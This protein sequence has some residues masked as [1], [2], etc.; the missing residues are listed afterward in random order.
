V[1]PAQ[2]E[3]VAFDHYT[4]KNGLSNNEVNDLIQDDDGF[5]WIATRG[6]LNRFDGKDFTKYYTDGSPEQLPSNDIYR[7]ARFSGNRILVGTLKG[8]A[9]FNTRTGKIS[10]HIIPGD[11]IL[12]TYRNRIVDIIVDSSQ[13]VIVATLTGVFV[14]DSAFKLIFRYEPFT[15]TD[16]GKKRIE[17]CYSFQLLK[18]GNI[19]IPA[20]NDVFLLDM[21]SKSMQS[22]GALAA[23]DWQLFNPWRTS[24]HQLFHWKD[25]S[26]CFVFNYI[27]KKDSLNLYE[28]NFARHRVYSM[29][30]PFAQK[31]EIHW[32]SNIRFLND[33]TIGINSSFQNGIYLFHFDS[34]ANSL[35]YSGKLLS[36]I[37]C[38]RI[39][40]D[41]EKRLWISSDD[42]VFKQSFQKS[43]FHN[44]YVRGI[45]GVHN[46]DNFV[47]GF[48]KIGNKLFVSVYSTGVII[49]GHQDKLQASGSR[50][51]IT[52]IRLPWNIIQTSK[53]SLLIPTQEGAIILNA[54][55]EIQ[56][57]FWKPGLPPSLDKVAITSIFLDSRNRLWMGM[58]K[59]F[60]VFMIN[61]NNQV[62]QIFDP[63]DGP[64]PFPIRYPVA[65]TE[66]RKGNIWMSGIEGI[67]RWNQFKQQF[68]TLI[69]HI[70]GLSEDISGQWISVQADTSGNLWI[71]P[72]EFVLIKWNLTNS[73]FK[74]FRTPVNMGALRA[75]QIQGPCNG[76]LWIPTNAGLLSFEI[77]TEKF[78][79]IKEADGLP[80]DNAID[81][82]MYFDST[83]NKMYAGFDKAFTWF[84][85]KKLLH[86]EHIPITYITDV[87]AIGD[88][89]SKA[90]YDQARFTHDQNSIS[91][92]FAGVN[93]DNGQ[94]N[95][96]AYRIFENQPAG[97][98][99]IGSQNTL[100]FANL[101]PG[102]YTFQVK[103][104]GTN[105]LSNS[106]M[107]GLV[108][109]ISPA[110]Y[111]TNWFFILCLLMIAFTLYALYRYRIQQ[112]L[113]V[114]KVR[115]NISSDLHDDIGARLTNMNILT[116]LSEQNL[117]NPEISGTYLSRIS[118]EIQ[119]SGEALDDIVWSINTNYDSIAE[120]IARM[121]R[122]AADQFESTTIAFE[123]KTDIFNTH[124][125]LMMDQR[126]DLFLVFKESIA[127]ILKHS[128]ARKVFIKIMNIKKQLHVSITD[129]GKGFD[130]SKPTHRHGI[131][132]MHARIKKWQG[133]LTIESSPVLGT[134]VTIC[135]P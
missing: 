5:I 119:S 113:R 38:N 92:S 74:I 27:T 71:C 105:E 28:L 76:I 101:K 106:G 103:T 96:Y 77:N 56:S 21:R 62:S 127:N 11:P 17:F 24:G 116:M 122:Y 99:S 6:G 94:S 65:M 90:G 111:Q 134:T 54:N 52:G 82:R 61:L 10:Q 63:G 44:T 80:G 7:L 84:E 117:G 43:L 89:F 97:W 91:I 125:K 100:N 115:N 16:L 69:K 78:N 107:A 93:F 33:S 9:S 23:S 135:M 102:K 64:H 3:P 85:P 40:T 20:T 48:A 109:I 15:G 133:K 45:E 121:R 34:A 59:G 126:R 75:H 36:G 39:F 46:I 26:R 72:E 124:H 29:N 104:I 35:I 53:D 67:T 49:Y 114:Q 2:D 47:N 128:G 88:S 112:L 131:Q 130:I 32:K 86:G 12:D 13:N 118:G 19:F 8:M 95:E 57:R 132:N 14:F 123:F 83:E 60:G 31:N 110:F 42:G 58:G 73:Q 18:N 37:Q 98:I 51:M 55:K 79:L 70:P 108:L 81:G 4:S 66:D 120:T 41:R 1:C 129:D 25:D 22:L 50:R 87:R 68:D 30:I